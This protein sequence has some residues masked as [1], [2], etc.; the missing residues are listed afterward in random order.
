MSF[1]PT[2]KFLATKEMAGPQR[3]FED[4]VLCFPVIFP[5]F[6]GLWS[7]TQISPDLRPEWT[8]T[9][10]V[11]THKVTCLERLT[12]EV[13]G[14]LIYVAQTPHV[15]STARRSG[16]LPWPL[17]SERQESLCQDAR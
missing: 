14:G 8:L 10:S 5:R 6:L 17:S 12:R 13:A 3:P 9:C 4:Q 2:K 15:L 11:A 7:G 16:W 1:F